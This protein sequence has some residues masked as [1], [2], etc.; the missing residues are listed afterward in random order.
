LDAGLLLDTFSPFPPTR[1]LC[2]SLGCDVTASRKK[3]TSP[4]RA[5]FSP[6]I[7]ETM[8]NSLSA[9]SILATVGDVN[10]W[11][12]AHFFVDLYTSAEDT[13]KPLNVD[14]VKWLHN[15]NETGSSKTDSSIANEV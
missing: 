9:A 6:S 13:A 14:L 2:K 5:L 4:H 12:V 8:D 11:T 1:H 10:H 7:T 15:D 3:C